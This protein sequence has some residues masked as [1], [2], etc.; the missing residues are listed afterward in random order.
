[1]TLDLDYPLDASEFGRCLEATKGEIQSLNLEGLSSDRIVIQNVPWNTSANSFPW[2]YVVPRI[3]QTNWREGN[4]EYDRIEYAVLV[5]MIFANERPLTGGTGL[6]MHWRR[7]IRKQFH[8][9]TRNDI[10]LD[11]SDL[12]AM[13]VRS[14]VQDGEAL[15]PEQMRSL[16]FGSWWLVRFVIDELNTE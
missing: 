9:K 10:A 14:Y 8:N 2:V 7:E 6:M 1:M 13:F 5:S 16:L 12:D 15:I 4:N 11:V 3:D